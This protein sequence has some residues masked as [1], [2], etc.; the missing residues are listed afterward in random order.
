MARTNLR[1]DDATWAGAARQH[2][3]TTSL[4][5]PP[6]RRDHSFTAVTGLPVR[7]Y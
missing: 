6:E 4:A 2:R 7:F 1:E 3:G 5:T